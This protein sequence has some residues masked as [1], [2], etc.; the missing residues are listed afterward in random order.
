M[1]FI[2]LFAAVLIAGVLSFSLESRVAYA[3]D[4]TVALKPC[5]GADQ[6]VYNDFGGRDGISHLV[7]DFMRELLADDRTRPFFEHADQQRIIL[8]LTDQICYA[9]GGPCE[10]KGLSM[11][12]AHKGLNIKRE[13]FNALV[14]DLQKSMNRFNIPFRSQNKL[15]AVLAPMHRDIEQAKPN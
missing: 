8:M 12:D 4:D 6:A 9:T 1:N 3:A 2:S 10:Y 5:C 7:N 14:E 11:T 15:L 13:D